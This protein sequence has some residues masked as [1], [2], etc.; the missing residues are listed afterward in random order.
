MSLMAAS[1]DLLLTF[2]ALEIL[3]ISTYVLAGFKRNEA[4]SNESA[5]KYF[6][7]GSF[8]TAFLLYG[9]ALIYGSSG[10]TNYQSIRTVIHLQGSAQVTAVAGLVLL[11]VG[12]GFKVALVPFHAWAPD[13]YEGAPTTVTAFMTVGPKAA[14]F[15]ALARVL[16]EAF[17]SLAGDWTSMLWAVAYSHD[18]AGKRRRRSA[19]EHQAHAGLLGHRARGIHPDRPCG[20]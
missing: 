7:L 15:A 12:F 20:Q 10:S 6:L 8:A 5:L 17:P 9:I 16:A 1:D 2:L 11:L 13:V 4:H 19:D 3:S 14:A 18:D